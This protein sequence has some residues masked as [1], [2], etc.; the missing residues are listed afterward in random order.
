MQ[1]LIIFLT[2][3]TN[4]MW[5]P[6]LSALAGGIL[7]LA[8]QAIDR[9]NKNRTE[10]ETSLRQ[11]YAYAR[12]LE[13]MMKNNYREL[14]MAKVHIEYWWHCHI[15]SNEGTN[16]RYYE[17]HLRSQSLAREIERKIGETKADFIGHIRK[18][19]AIKEI[20][21][22]IE[23]DLLII[24]DLTHA[25]AKPYELDLQHNQVRYEFAENDERELRDLYFENLEHFKRINDYLFTQLKINDEDDD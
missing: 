13:A 20:K 7:V 21:T 16:G 5:I 4:S 9:G 17:E 12:K 10:K 14:A 15:T 18:F 19:Q 24:S 25:K 1:G 23:N 3:N 6:F 2:T 11:I 8:G 22:D